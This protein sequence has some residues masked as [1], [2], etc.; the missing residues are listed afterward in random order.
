MVFFGA[1]FPGYSLENS[2]SN[3]TKQDFLWILFMQTSFLGKF[4]QTINCKSFLV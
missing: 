2:A 4:Y 3:D 1:F